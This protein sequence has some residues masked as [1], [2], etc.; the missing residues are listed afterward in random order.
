MERNPSVSFKHGSGLPF[1]EIVLR[2]YIPF[3]FPWSLARTMLYGAVH[4]HLHPALSKK[5]LYGPG[6]A[7][8]PARSV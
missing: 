6:W 3:R 4:H 1:I 5:E 7:P 2:R 8:V